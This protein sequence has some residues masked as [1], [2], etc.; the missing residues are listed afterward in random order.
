MVTGN[1]SEHRSRGVAAAIAFPGDVDRSP[2]DLLLREILFFKVANWMIHRD[3]C[4]C[5]AQCRV[6]R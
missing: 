4:Y 3:V 1:E 2:N 6:Q 5:T